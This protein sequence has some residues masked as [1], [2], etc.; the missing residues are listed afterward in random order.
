MNKAYHIKDDRY[1]HLEKDA[2]FEK[3]KRGISNR[4]LAADVFDSNAWLVAIRQTLASAPAEHKTPQRRIQSAGS[5]ALGDDSLPI[6]TTSNSSG[7][8]NGI[9]ATVSTRKKSALNP[10]DCF[11]L[12]GT[13]RKGTVMIQWLNPLHRNKYINVAGV[14]NQATVVVT[15]FCPGKSSLKQVVKQFYK[16]VMLTLNA[17]LMVTFC[18]EQ[19]SF[20]LHVSWTPPLDRTRW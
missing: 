5:I 18:S 6:M 2:R 11:A 17:T 12:V 1:S 16:S 4:T 15:E 13:N 10:P 9:E 19:S 20:S 8:L 7:F 14:M 3:L